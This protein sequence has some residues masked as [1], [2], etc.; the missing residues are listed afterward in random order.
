MPI[1]VI[2]S[3]GILT[4][5]MYMWKIITSAVF[6]FWSSSV[7]NYQVTWIVSW[8]KAGDYGLTVRGHLSEYNGTGGSL[9]KGNVLFEYKLHLM[10][11]KIPM[12]IIIWGLNICTINITTCTCIWKWPCL[13]YLFPSIATPSFDWVMHPLMH[14]Y[15][16]Q[17][18]NTGGVK[19]GNKD[20]YMLHLAVIQADRTSIQWQQY[21]YNDIRQNYL[22]NKNKLRWVNGKG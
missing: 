3:I 13:H 15:S 14:S 6:Q 8:Y 17:S 22:L 1:N 20:M 16:M 12:N 2:V 4:T 10:H 11:S 7:S 19:S 5:Y 9:D 21:M 18:L